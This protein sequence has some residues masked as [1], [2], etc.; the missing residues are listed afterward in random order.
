MTSFD[1]AVS[2]ESFLHIPDKVQ[3]PVMKCFA[4]CALVAGSPLPIG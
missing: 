2:Q 1:A 4:S 3:G